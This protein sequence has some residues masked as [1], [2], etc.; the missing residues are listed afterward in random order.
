[1][2]DCSGWSANGICASVALPE[3]ISRTNAGPMALGDAV[4]MNDDQ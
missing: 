1:M 4:A 3:P 2:K